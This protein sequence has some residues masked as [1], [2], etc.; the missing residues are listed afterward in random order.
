MEKEM[1][2]LQIIVGERELDIV[3]KKLL[4]EKINELEVDLRTM[5]QIEVPLKHYFSKDVYA[6]EIIVPK[7]AL[8][9]GKIHKHAN[10]N[11]VSKG[12]ISVVSIDGIKTITA[13]ATFVSSPGVKRVGYAHEDTVWT[14]IHGTSETD[15]EKIE[16]EFIAK[17]YD[18]VQEL[19]EQE[20]KL[21]EEAKCRG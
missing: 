10:L 14:C 6:R 3:D 5:E 11:I 7:G 12:K 17:D 13:P 9:I 1:N 8:L 20:L 2:A 15:L 4:K 18:E 16:A 21:I 19:T